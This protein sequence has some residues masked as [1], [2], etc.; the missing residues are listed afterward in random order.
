MY[1]NILLRDMSI[2]I[3]SIIHLSIAWENDITLHGHH[4][5]FKYVCSIRAKKNDF[6]IQSITLKCH[7][8]FCVAPYK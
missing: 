5:H 6:H 8:S 4:A 2:K 7:V 1:S 3:R